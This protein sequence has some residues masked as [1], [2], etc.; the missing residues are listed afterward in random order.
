MKQYSLG[1]NQWL[2][3]IDSLYK[4]REIY[5]KIDEPLG[6]ISLCLNKKLASE[7]NIDFND[8]ELIYII[9]ESISDNFYSHVDNFL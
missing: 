1:I 4:K 9:K 8:I 5:N 6:S 2:G 3:S 7:K